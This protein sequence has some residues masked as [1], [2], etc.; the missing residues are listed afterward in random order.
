MNISNHP[1]SFKF[2]FSFFVTDR[3]ACR[4][5]FKSLKRLKLTQEEWKTGLFLDQVGYKLFPNILAAL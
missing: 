5:G 2:H 4:Q 3:G 1:Y